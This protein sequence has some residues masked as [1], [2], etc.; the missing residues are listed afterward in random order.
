VV[1]DIGLAREGQDDDFPRGVR[2]PAEVAL[3]WS[4]DAVQSCSPWFGSWAFLPFI[5]KAAAR[6]FVPPGP[7]ASLPIVNAVSAAM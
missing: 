2:P 3:Y 1:G 6:F 4:E 5:A 7:S